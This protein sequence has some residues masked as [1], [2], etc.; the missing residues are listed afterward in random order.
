MSEDLLEEGRVLRLPRSKYD[1]AAAV[2]M[3]SVFALSK[4]LFSTCRSFGSLPVYHYQP[5]RPTP[6]RPLQ[7]YVSHLYLSLCCNIL[8]SYLLVCHPVVMSQICYVHNRAVSNST[9]K[10][11]NSKT[12]SVKT[13]IECPFVALFGHCSLY[14]T[15]CIASLLVGNTE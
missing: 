12:I 5:F 7:Q 14:N 3:D 4:Q 1:I 11:S 8:S 13:P 6:P 2:G 9:I 10:L 15:K